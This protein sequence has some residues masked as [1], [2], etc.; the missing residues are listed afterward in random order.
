MKLH[1]HDIRKCGRKKGKENRWI[2]YLQTVPKF[3]QLRIFYL[4]SHLL[5]KANVSNTKQYCG[6]TLTDNEYTSELILI[7]YCTHISIPKILKNTKLEYPAFF[8]HYVYNLNNFRFTHKLENGLT[9]ETRKD[10]KLFK[11]RN[12]RSKHISF[13]FIHTGYNVINVCIYLV[14]LLH[15]IT[16]PN[17]PKKK[18]SFL[19]VYT[20]ILHSL[21][22]M[23]S[24][25]V[26]YHYK[27]KPQEAM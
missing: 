16:L 21:H 15:L 17:K 8:Q 7:N 26:F 23:N 14:K 24:R 25:D 6:E 18:L 2:E 27:A 10:S 22:R 1:K 20:L 4:F 12:E 3:T 9:S 19:H 5:S 11:C 13:P